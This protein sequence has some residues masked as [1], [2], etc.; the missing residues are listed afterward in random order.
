LMSMTQSNE[1][2]LE[3]MSQIIEERLKMLQDDNAKKLEKMRGTVDEKLHATLEKR[4]NDSFKIVSER[5]E[6]V[7][8]GLGEMQHLATGVGD[9][10]KVL[11]NVKARGTW[12]E[13][14]L[15][16]LLE[17]VL[18]QGQYE[19]NVATKKGSSERVEFAIKLPGRDKDDKKEVFL[20]IDAKFPIEDYQRLVDAQEKANP[21]LA[22]QASKQLENR[23]KSAAKD[24]RNKYLN[25]PFT[26]DFGIMYLPTEGLYAEVSRKPDLLQLLQRDYRIVVAGPNNLAAF[27]NS[28]QMGFRTLAIEKR[29]SEVWEILGMVKTEFSK[30]GDILDKTYKK[31]QEAGNTI[32]SASKTSRTIERKLRKVQTLPEHEVVPLLDDGLIEEV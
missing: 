25:P 6:K 8:Q 2:R 26:T 1:K 20:P 28:L 4:L 19:Q 17:Q 29:S 22:A 5:L 23:I 31:I 27:L 21:E 24:I 7:H 10:K 32:E 3:K 13:I 11:T 12:G 30:F 18:N 14:Q 16:N 15:G 9:L